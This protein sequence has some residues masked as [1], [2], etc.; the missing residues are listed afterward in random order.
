MREGIVE[1]NPVIATN[2]AIEKPSRDR[3]LIETELA[4]IWAASRDDDYGRCVR[5]LMLTGQR[6]EAV[7][8]GMSST[9]S[10]ASGACRRSARRTIVRILC[11]SPHV[12]SQ[13]SN[14]PRGAH[15]GV[16]DPSTYSAWASAASGDGAAPACG[17]D[18]VRSAGAAV[19]WGMAREARSKP[20]D[21]FEA[22][23]KQSYA[24]AGKAPRRR[25]HSL[26]GIAAI[27]VCGL[28][29]PR[30]V[31][32]YPCASSAVRCRTLFVLS[33]FGPHTVQPNTSVVRD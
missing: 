13:F 7:Y 18:R 1:Q 32:G 20:A 23:M 22:S 24:S 5:L 2:I 21:A 3:V 27:A 19:A 16:M 11:R 6:R 33:R 30:I 28:P 31:I 9:S 25:V 29:P 10:A 8:G 17:R 14:L 12:Q 4:A 26:S 15:G